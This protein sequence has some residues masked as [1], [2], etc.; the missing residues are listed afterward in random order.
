LHPRQRSDTWPKKKLDLLKFATSLMAQAGAG[1]PKIVR[2][3]SR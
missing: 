3:G 1:P 2:G